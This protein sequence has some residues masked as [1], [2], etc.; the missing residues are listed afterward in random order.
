[1]DA[2]CISSTH[3]GGL[4]LDASRPVPDLH[5]IPAAVLASAT[6][7][8]PQRRHRRAQVR[9]SR[10]ARATTAHSERL[11]AAH[12]GGG[13]MDVLRL[14]QTLTVS[15]ARP[16]RTRSP[17]G[18]CRGA[19]CGDASPRSG[20][21]PCGTA[22]ERAAGAW[23]A[24]RARCAAAGGADGCGGRGG[25][26]SLIDAVGD[27]VA[28]ASPARWRCALAS[29]AAARAASSDGSEGGSC[30]ASTGRLPSRNGGSMGCEHA[31]SRHRC[32]GPRRWRPP[33]PP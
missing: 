28:G 14:E 12:A 29:S 24:R 8:A 4:A 18:A 5:T 10:A 1:M 32:S 30:G 23:C 25:A 22:R 27:F 2:G 31:H 33:A 19:H 21:A 20:G 9:Q 17:L 11:T 3:Q 16:A 7:A 13:A 6:A 26:A 15:A